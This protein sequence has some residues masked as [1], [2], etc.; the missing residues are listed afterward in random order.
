MQFLNLSFKDASLKQEINY[1][2]IV[3]VMELNTSGE[4]WCLEIAEV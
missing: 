3:K 4:D 2:C 1:N